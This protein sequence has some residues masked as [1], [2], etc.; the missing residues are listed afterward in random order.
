MKIDWEIVVSVALA[1]ILSSI[2]VSFLKP[3]LEKFGIGNFEEEE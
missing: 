3:Q 2:A 1:I